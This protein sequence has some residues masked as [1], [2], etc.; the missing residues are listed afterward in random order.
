MD[1]AKN[2][3]AQA[4]TIISEEHQPILMDSLHTTEMESILWQTVTC[5]MCD[6]MDAVFHSLA[7]DFRIVIP[8]GA[9]SWQFNTACIKLWDNHHRHTT[10]LYS[11]SEGNVTTT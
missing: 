8:E 3:I 6:S 5:N 11:R 1:A 9:V 10:S 4:H 2:L 7:H